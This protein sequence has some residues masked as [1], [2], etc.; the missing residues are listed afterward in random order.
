MNLITGNP[1]QFRAGDIVG[2]DIFGTKYGF[3]GKS[4]KYVYGEIVS[5][6]NMDGRAV[7]TVKSEGDL[8]KYYG[9]TLYRRSYVQKLINERIGMFTSNKFRVKCRVIQAAK[10]LQIESPIV[11]CKIFEIFNEGKYVKGS[12]IIDAAYEYLGVNPNDADVKQFVSVYGREAEEGINP[13]SEYKM[14]IGN[15]GALAVAAAEKNTDTN[16]K[17]IRDC[18][19]FTKNMRECID[20]C[21]LNNEDCDIALYN[22]INS[23]DSFTGK[24]IKDAIKEYTKTRGN[25]PVVDKFITEYINFND[26]TRTYGIANDT[27]YFLKIDNYYLM[28]VKDAAAVGNEDTDSE[29]IED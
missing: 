17:R 7:I 3:V 24:E 20:E 19:R 11:K 29:N 23:K 21:K 18:E 27:K 2:I 28:A 25:D 6:D 12:E 14:Y 10:G 16:E 8:R 4:A 13:D 5:V 26:G 22:I 1:G 15:D 9:E